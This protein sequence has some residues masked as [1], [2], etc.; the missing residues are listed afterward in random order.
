LIYLEEFG[1]QKNKICNI[2]K[3]KVIFLLLSHLQNFP[4]LRIFGDYTKMICVQIFVNIRTQTELLKLLTNPCGGHSRVRTASERM[5][6]HAIIS[7]Q[8]AR[9]EAVGTSELQIARAAAHSK[10]IQMSLAFNV[11]VCRDRTGL[12]RMTCGSEPQLHRP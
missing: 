2:F 4:L 1:L 3:D 5:Q 6:P 11:L 8:A 12:C 7:I 10:T 9:T